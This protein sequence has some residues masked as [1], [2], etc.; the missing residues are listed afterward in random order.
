MRGADYTKKV[1]AQTE[2]HDYCMYVAD[3][4]GV[5]IPPLTGGP[6]GGPFHYYLL[7]YTSSII[8]YYCILFHAHYISTPSE[9]SMLHHAQR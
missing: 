6:A 8:L 1:I 5:L 2:E 3:L 7:R 4:F 9:C